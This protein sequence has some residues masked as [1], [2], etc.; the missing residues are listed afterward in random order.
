VQ[1]TTMSESLS[2][3]STFCGKNQTVTL[4]LPRCVLLLPLSSPLNLAVIVSVCAR[5]DASK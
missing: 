2:R 3:Q 4:M 1:F 5:P